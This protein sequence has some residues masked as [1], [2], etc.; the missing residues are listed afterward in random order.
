MLDLLYSHP[1]D[2]IPFQITGQKEKETQKSRC[3]YQYFTKEEYVMRAKYI[4]SLLN[5][6]CSEG[7][8]LPTVCEIKLRIW[9]LIKV[10]LVSAV[11]VT[12]HPEGQK[13]IHIMHY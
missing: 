12:G 9:L 11:A 2:T 1:H 7:L 3:H 10:K 4:S 6:C 5:M 13:H 8:P